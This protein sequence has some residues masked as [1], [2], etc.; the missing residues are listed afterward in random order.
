MEYSK[1]AILQHI[2]NPMK[3]LFWEVDE[4]MSFFIPF[5]LLCLNSNTG[6]GFI[7]GAMAFFIFRKIKGNFSSTM[8]QVMYWYLPSVKKNY[9][10][11]VKS[12]VM[13]WLV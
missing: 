9:Q 6:I 2:N 1:H 10:C 3:I 13:E 12:Y 8:S 7:I 5:V 11:H 4:A